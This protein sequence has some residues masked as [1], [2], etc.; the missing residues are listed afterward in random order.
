MTRLFG[1]ILLLIILVFTV[2]T[3]QFIKYDV[4]GLHAFFAQF[5]STLM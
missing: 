2:C 4:F 1:F 5:Q 3:V